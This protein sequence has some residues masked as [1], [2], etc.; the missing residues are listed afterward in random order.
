MHWNSASISNPGINRKMKQQN[1]GLAANLE[2]GL[3][4][5]WG[6]W[7]PDGSQAKPSER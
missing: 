3:Y 4:L 2:L 6:C 5:G 1:V 7:L